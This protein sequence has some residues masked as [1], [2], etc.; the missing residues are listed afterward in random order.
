MRRPS[1]V[2]AGPFAARLLGLRLEQEGAVDHDRLAGL[3]AGQDLDLAAQVAARGRRRAP[4]RRPPPAARRRTTGRPGA[5]APPPARRGRVRLRP[6]AATRWPTCRASARRSGLGSS[7]R[8][9]IVREPISTWLPT[10]RTRAPRACPGSAGMATRALAP[11][12]NTDR[13][14]LGRVRH[15]PQRRERA[16]AEEGLRRARPPGPGPGSA[17]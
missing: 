7:S 15:Q 5:A 11:G 14:A 6:P 16:D 13:V 1:V 8:T 12:R 4:R 9:G 10:S 17:R 2:M 3:E